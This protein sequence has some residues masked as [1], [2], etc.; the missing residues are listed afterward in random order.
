MYPSMFSNTKL[1]P[2][3]LK[4]RRRRKNPEHLNIWNLYL[5]KQ[6]SIAYALCAYVCVSVCAWF[7]GSCSLYFH[8][9]CSIKRTIS[10]TLPVVLQSIPRCSLWA[11]SLP[12]GC[13]SSRPGLLAGSSVCF[14]RCP[15]PPLSLPARLRGNDSWSDAAADDYDSGA[16]GLLGPS[17][18]I[19]WLFN[20]LQTT[21]VVKRWLH[22]YMVVMYRA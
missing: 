5:L 22:L 12:L 13:I 8:E 16:R 3:C 4:W 11:V 10:P 9:S 21:W 1:P 6:P 14:S 2:K 19:Q 18:S 17:E 20:L 7:V 15:P